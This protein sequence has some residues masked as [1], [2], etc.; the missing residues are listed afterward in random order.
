MVSIYIYDIGFLILF[1][2]FVFLFLRKNRKGLKKEGIMYLYRTRVGIKFID[3]VGTKYKRFLTVYAFIGVIVG[4]LLMASMMWFLWKLLEVYLFNP[5]IVRAIKIPPLMPLIPYLPEAFGVS[6]L[7]PFYFTYWIISIAVIALF[8]EFAHGII[9]RRY[10]IRI[11]TTGFGFLGP[12]LAAFVEP[13]E[14]EMEDKPKYQQLAVLSAGVFTNLILAVLFFLLLSVFFLFAYAPAGALFNTYSPG[15]IEIAGIS[16]IGGQLVSDSSS[17]GILK[18]IEENGIEDSLVL[19]D[20]GND[21]KLTEVIVNG[22]TYYSNIENLEY[23]LANPVEDG[24]VALFEDLPAI[25]AGLRG[26]IIGINELEVKD[27]KELGLVLSGFEVGDTITV[28]TS[29][30]GELLEYELVLGEDSNEEGRAVMGIGLLGGGGND[31][32]LSEITEFF[33]FFKE[34]GTN[35]EPRFN[36]ELVLFIYNLIWWLALINLSV[37]LINMWPVA[38]FDGGRF[39]MLSVWAITGS[40]K[41]AMRAFKFVTYAILASLALLMLGWFWAIF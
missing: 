41:F 31:R 9:A 16:M 1:S 30:E 15:V 39:F 34:D 25:N 5:E 4:Y 2:L 18:V 20:P 28:K 3:Y 36:P 22:E 24:L 10:N 38:I 13:D 27:G 12:F 35:Y 17:T 14:K 23:Q 33:N 19:G 6:F 29:D 21:L 26:A 37:A 11:L 8:H 7:P 32:I 40:E